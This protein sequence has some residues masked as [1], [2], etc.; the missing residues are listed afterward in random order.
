MVATLG[1]KAHAQAVRRLVDS[2]EQIAGD[3]PVRLAKRTSNL[4]R[5]RSAS[6][7]PGLDVSGL[8]GV[9]AIDPEAQAADVQAMCTYEDLVDVT[10]AHGMIP[11]VVPQLRTIT[12]GGAVT[13]LGIEST[14]FRNGLP[15]ESVIEM[16]VL[17]GSGEIVTADAHGQNADL[18]AT[19]PNSYGS[20]GYAT[21]IKI[22]LE[23]VPGFV[24]LRHIRFDTVT[25]LADAVE[26]I[27]RTRSW[28]GVR[29]DGLDGVAFSPS[30][31]Y[32]T[33]ATNALE[34]P[35]TLSSYTG[36][37]IYYRSIRQ[38]ETDALTMY[39]Y[40]WR[41]DTDWFWC[42]AAFGAQNR[43]AR[44][45]WPA[46]YRRSDFYHRLAGYDTRFGLVSKLDRVRRKPQRERI[47]QDV[48]V[49]VARIAEFIDWFDE[50]IGM[51][52]VWLCPLRLREPDGSGSSRAWP[53]Y[54]LVPGR[55]YVNAGF[56]GTVPIAEGA[57]DGDKNKL[58]EATVTAMGGHKSLYS[59]A[60][61]DR[62]TFDRL[63]DG[64]ALAQ[65]RAVH[66]PNERLTGLYEK[67]VRGQ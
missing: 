40:L 9:I 23:Q 45:I 55:T 67:A 11:M 54:P 12:L 22:A 16:D 44:R 38:R 53:L 18:F 33:L 47:I 2:F 1:W 37:R 42:S 25:A 5:A 52:P 19:F 17:T 61:Y 31:S 39:D 36:Q 28:D 50:N 65:V 15:H 29:V 3:A 64:A 62:E 57:S 48:E 51:R 26:R 41:W 56:W 6:T 13:G 21:R 8:A 63:Y 46:R 58:I 49:P 32:L 66:D 4:F 7:A 30:E 27:V 20:L 14:S 24:E 34:R 43:L 59:D 10:L 60:Y 35:S